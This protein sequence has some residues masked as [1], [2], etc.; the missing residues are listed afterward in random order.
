VSSQPPSR[1]DRRKQETRDRIREAA[2]ELFVEQ[3]YEGT[4]VSEICEQ[5]DVARQTFFNH[6][7]S[8]RHVA[9]DVFEI[10]LDMMETHVD[11]ACEQADA[12]RDRL[13]IFFALAVVPAVETGPFNREFVAQVINSGD[14]A[15]DENHARR[16]SAI[17]LRLV[18]RGLAQGDVTRRHAPE[19]LAELV[20]GAVMTLMRDWT[21][22]GGFDPAARAQQM[23]ALVADAIEARP[24]ERD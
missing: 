18:Q 17:F 15:T 20:E 1:A 23:A 7:P 19:I 24:D 13:R 4:K 3:G 12:I 21:A 2:V 9:T 6:F 5:A 22:R 8:K 14:I 10:G 16:A 11:T